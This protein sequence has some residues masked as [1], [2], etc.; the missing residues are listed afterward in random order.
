MLNRTIA[1]RSRPSPKAQP[2]LWD[3]SG[4]SSVSRHG[5]NLI[6]FGDKGECVAKRRQSGKTVRSNEEGERGNVQLRKKRESI[7][8]KEQEITYL[9]GPRSF[10]ER[11]HI[12]TTPATLRST[13]LQPHNWVR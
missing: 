7:V 5:G 6:G 12:P 3:W 13:K 4:V 11:P 10:A 9:L 1:I 8:R 2:A